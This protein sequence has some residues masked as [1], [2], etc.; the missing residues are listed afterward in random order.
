MFKCEKCGA[1]CRM[2]GQTPFF[3]M[4]ALP[5]GE[6]KWLDTDTNLCRIYP[7]RPLICNIDEMYKNY[8]FRRYT[9]EEFYQLNQNNC[10]LIR[11]TLKKNGR[12][13]DDRV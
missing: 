8:Y 4:F 12:L 2:I 11:S 13:K 3:R 1:C 10:R 5:S 6:C 7:K 9:R